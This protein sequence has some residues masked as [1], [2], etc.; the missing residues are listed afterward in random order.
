MVGV[1]AYMLAASPPGRVSPL[2]SSEIIPLLAML[3]TVASAFVM[4]LQARA[5]RRKNARERRAADAVDRQDVLQLKLDFYGD[6]RAG[7]PT[8]QG[9]LVLLEA[10]ADQV[11]TIHAEITPNHGGSMKD[12]IVRIDTRVA[13]LDADVKGLHAQ[14]KQ[15]S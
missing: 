4:I 8:R 12:A 10:L 14:I 9:V 5:E 6:Q 1:V 3:A 11:E 15:G 2:A 13:S 7:V